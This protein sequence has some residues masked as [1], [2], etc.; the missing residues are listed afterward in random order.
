[1]GT[2]TVNISANQ[3]KEL[4]EKTGAPMMDCKQALTEAKGDLEQAVILL[5]KRGVSV[6]AKKATRVTSEGS[7]A[8]Y[9]HAGGKIGV[10]LEVNCE[11]DFVARTEDFKEMVHD[12]AMHIA[13]SD[14]KFVRKEDVT[15]EAYEREKD[16]YRA[17]AAATGKPPQVVEKI[18]EGKMS[19]FYEEVCLYEQPFIKDQTISIGQ[20]IATKIGKLGENIAVSRF[21]R[22]K[23]GDAGATV[24]FSSNKGEEPG[25][26]APVGK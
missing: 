5:R 24:A 16:I 8:S 1:M 22:F 23:V 6:A 15:S 17:Q 19:K 3:V 7:V 4:R 12:I 2:S 20:L 9:I 18:V 10:L 25:E 26:S 14:P 13:A 11:S 21:A